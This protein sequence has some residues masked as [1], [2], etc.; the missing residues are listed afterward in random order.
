VGSTDYIAN[1]CDM[2]SGGGIVAV[3]LGDVAVSWFV[4]PLSGSGQGAASGVVTI[5]VERSGVFE[6]IRGGSLIRQIRPGNNSLY[7]YISYSVLRTC[8]ARSK[9]QSRLL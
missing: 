6:V 5:R 3:E 9:R 4:A 8:N 1:L 7:M 2:G